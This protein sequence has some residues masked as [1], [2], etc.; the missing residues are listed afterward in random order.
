ME[1]MGLP[2]VNYA[3]EVRWKGNKAQQKKLNAV[4][5]QINNGGKQIRRIMCSDG[6][7]WVEI[8]DSEEQKMRYMRGELVNQD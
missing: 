7:T 4:Q 2:A 5:E 3:A 1:A 8:Y 6:R